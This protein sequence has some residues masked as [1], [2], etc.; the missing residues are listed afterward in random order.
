MNLFKYLS[1]T[2][3]TEKYRAP[4]RVY[5]MSLYRVEVMP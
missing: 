3:N 2:E 4:V 5:D 1:G